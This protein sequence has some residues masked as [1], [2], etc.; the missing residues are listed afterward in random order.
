MTSQK[1]AGLAIGRVLARP[2]TSLAPRILILGGGFAGVTTAME[3]AKRCAG[4]L[5]VHITLLSEQNFFLFTPMLAEAATGAVE[6]RHVL[7]PIRPL[8]GA[9]GI[10]FGEMCV[11][12]VDL[13]RRRVVAR[14]RRSQ[15]R[16]HV[17]YDKLVLALGA[18]P[19]VA[20]VPGAAEHALPFKGVGDAVRIRNRVIDLFEA[21]ALTEDPWARQRLLTFVVVG[22]GHAGT[23][24]MAALEEL[25]R[26]IL[27]RHYPSL[28]RNS[29]RLVLVGSAVLPQTAT[30]LAAYAREQILERGIE[31]ET[32]RAARVLPE[33]LVLQDGRVIPSDCVIW[34]AGNRVSPVVADLPLPKAPDGR[35][36]VNE[37]FEV[38]EAPHVYALGDNAAQTDPH[39]NSSYVATA[40]VAIRQARALARQLEAELTGRERRPFRF[41]VLGEMV[42]LSRRTAVADL[43]GIKLIGFPAWFC[44][45]TVYML[46]LPTLAA[47][48][49]VVL[50]WTVELFFERDVSELTVDEERGA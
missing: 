6:S 46:K 1:E 39:T 19:N 17:H 49:R 50:D 29:V 24:L 8:C 22:A 27:L 18:T 15:M 34:T 14:H 43:R 31:L 13:H 20:M 4:V 25:T 11:E 47:R 32:N 40:Q 26:A 5:P 44:W 7:Y 33:G 21:A 38:K 23:E 10:E 16:Q 41:R 12:A 2:S 48:V 9:W 36:L 42:P 35:L 28:A 37:F 30:N 3:L 45:K